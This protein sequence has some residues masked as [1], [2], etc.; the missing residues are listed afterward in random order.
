MNALLWLPAVIVA[1]L[2]A[3]D[4]LRDRA[5]QRRDDRE[6]SKLRQLLEEDPP[7]VTAQFL[8][9]AALGILLGAAYSAAAA[10]AVV[11]WRKLRAKETS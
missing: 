9:Y 8:K 11:A 7:M 6:W 10:V 5:R 4:V 3:V 2:I 1:L